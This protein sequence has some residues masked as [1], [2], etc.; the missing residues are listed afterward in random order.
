MAGHRYVS[1]TE[2]YLVNDLEDLSEEI[3]KFHPMG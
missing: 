2:G 1:T 3:T